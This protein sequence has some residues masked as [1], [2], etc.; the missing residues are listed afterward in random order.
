LAAHVEV[1]CERSGDGWT[2]Q[3]AVDAGSRRTQHHVRVAGADLDRWGRGGTA[4]DL[5]TRA[6]E[7]LLEREPPD[8]ILRQFDLAII[9]RYF[10]DFDQDFRR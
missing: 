2:C 8:S 7:F 5:V 4:E 1:R 3:V 6:F 9:Q 10:P